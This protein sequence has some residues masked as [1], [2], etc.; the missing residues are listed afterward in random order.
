MSEPDIYTIKLADNEP[1]QFVKHADYMKL[2]CSWKEMFA[3]GI[4]VLRQERDEMAKLK[5]ENE[6]LTNN[7]DKLCK[8]GDLE[9]AR[10]RAEVERLRKAGDWMYNAVILNSDMEMDKAMDAW[11]AAKEGKQS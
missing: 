11:N 4:Q 8:H 7:T 6:R 5:A 9:I 2:H 3:D 10:L 1:E